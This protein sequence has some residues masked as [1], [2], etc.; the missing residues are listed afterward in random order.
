M[1][2]YILKSPRNESNYQIFVLYCGIYPSET[3][4]EM[5]ENVGWDL[6]SHIEN[7]LVRLEDGRC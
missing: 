6:I 1:C 7:G 3:A 5:R 4:S 2:F